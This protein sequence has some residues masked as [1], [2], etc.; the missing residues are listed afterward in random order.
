MSSAQS[1]LPLFSGA[2][3]YLRPDPA[4]YFVIASFNPQP[5]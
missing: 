1:A 2:F 4:F 5:E 3:L